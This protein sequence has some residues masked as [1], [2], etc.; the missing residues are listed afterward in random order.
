MNSIT[1]KM[2]FD[3]LLYRGMISNQIRGQI[4]ERI[5]SLKG[6]IAVESENTSSSYTALSELDDILS[7]ILE[8]FNT[9]DSSLLQE[10]YDSLK[11]WNEV[12]GKCLNDRL[13]FLNLSDVISYLDSFC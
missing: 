7:K 2:T 12:K 5:E 10:A 6:Y 13:S 8:S 9:M 3:D 4:A 1:N 11:K